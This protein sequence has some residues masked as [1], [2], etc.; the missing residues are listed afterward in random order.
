[1]KFT[2]SGRV[3]IRLIGLSGERLRFEVE[4]TG[5]GVPDERRHRLFE[6]FSQ[7]DPSITRKYGGAGLGLA[8]SKR[9]WRRWAAGSGSKAGKGSA[10][11]SGS[12][13]PSGA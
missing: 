2:S 10:A 8:I 11:R 6:E 1:M 5:I 12:R 4:D 9:L 13:R 7:G 3:T